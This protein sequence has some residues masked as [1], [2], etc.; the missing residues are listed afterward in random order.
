MLKHKN[1]LCAVLVCLFSLTSFAQQTPPTTNYVPGDAF[2]PLFYTQNGNEYRSASGAP[3]AKILAN[4]VDYNITATLDDTK[5]MVSGTITITYKNNSPDKLPYLW[6]QLDQ[7]TF[8]E[9]SRGYAV[10]P[11]VSRYGAQGEKFDGGYK[12][13]NISV[14]QKALPVKFTS[15]VEDTRMQIRLDQPM[16]AMVI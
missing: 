2:G 10:T 13:K 9:T 3:R 8:K 14:S 4:R 6:L 5:N 15:L 7:N 1:F 11:P 12:I 16:A